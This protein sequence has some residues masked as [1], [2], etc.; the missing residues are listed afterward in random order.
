MLHPNTSTPVLEPM[1]ALAFYLA[2]Y[3]DTWPD[4]IALH[5]KAFAD[6]NHTPACRPTVAGSFR[7][8]R[9]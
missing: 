6:H 8:Q 3:L 7:T 5:Q 2:S 1:R 4:L 9:T